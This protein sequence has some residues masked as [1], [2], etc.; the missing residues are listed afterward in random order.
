[1][2]NIDADNHD[3]IGIVAID[4]KGN[5]ASGA[6]TN[7]LTYKIPGYAIVLLI[8]FCFFSHYFVIVTHVLSITELSHR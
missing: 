5:I 2:N 1:M 4:A 8:F 3:T 6:S 7:G